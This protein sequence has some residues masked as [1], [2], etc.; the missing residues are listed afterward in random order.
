MGGFVNS[1]NAAGQRRLTLSDDHCG[2]SVFTPL[3]SGCRECLFPRFARLVEGDVVPQGRD[4]GRE[5]RRL[6]VAIVLTGVPLDALVAELDSNRNAI[7]KSVFDARRK[8]RA[9][10]V[11]NGYL[12][13]D[14]PRRP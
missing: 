2:G 5:Q 6:F 9:N 13:H 3:P 10:L 8:L 14:T 7:Y 12:D 11:A 4:G 1:V